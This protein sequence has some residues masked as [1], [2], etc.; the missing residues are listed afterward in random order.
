MA[1]TIKAK[2]NGKT[3]AQL[4]LILMQAYG[5]P[6]TA[7]EIM[8]IVYPGNK[9]ESQISDELRYM[10]QQGK[11]IRTGTPQQY[12]YELLEKKKRNYFYVMQN[13]TFA[14]EYSGGYLWA[15]QQGNNGAAANHSWSR[16]QS[17]KAGDVIIHGYKQQVVAISIA[18]SDC[19]SAQ[20]PE[21]LVAD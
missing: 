14:E 16:M 10:F 4:I 3:R 19:Y 18:K 7:R 11:V 20:R 1:D 21:E 12:F 17:V 13:K 6:V 9:N 15:P 5:R 2:Q 8:N